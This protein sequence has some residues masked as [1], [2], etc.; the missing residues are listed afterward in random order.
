MPDQPRSTTDVTLATNP[1]DTPPNW[2]LAPSPTK[3][4]LASMQWATGLNK[5]KFG[6][7]RDGGT[8]FH[9]GIDIKAAVGTACFATEAAKVKDVGW[10]GE[11]GQCVG[12]SFTK[13]GKTYGVAYCHLQEKVFVKVGDSVKAGDKLGETGLSGNAETSNPHLHLEVQ[14]QVWVAYNPAE[15]RS[16]H[17][18]NPNSY[19]P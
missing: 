4:P 8:K 16:K 11:L 14:D 10:F 12:I 7:T 1:C 3:N 6:C 15:D 19:I 5:D 17:A 9:A 2:P 18:L 13:N